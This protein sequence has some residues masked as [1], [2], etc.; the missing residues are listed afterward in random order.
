MV[1]PPLSS[2]IAP[3]LV[4]LS[5]SFTVPTSSGFSLTRDKDKRSSISENYKTVA[6]VVPIDQE[7]KI[8]LFNVVDDANSTQGDL[9]KV[10]AEVWVIKYGFLS[11]TMA[12]LVQQFAKVSGSL[13][14][15]DLR[16]ILQR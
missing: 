16:R 1:N 12:T 6:N 2:G 10:V 15:A 5:F 3:S 7:V 14:K 8:P 11:S 4:K 13:V 9:G